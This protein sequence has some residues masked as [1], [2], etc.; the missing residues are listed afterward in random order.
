MY[1][2]VY[3]AFQAFASHDY[4]TAGAEIG[5]AMNDLSQWTTGHS[6]SDDFCYVVTGIMQAMGDMQG[7]LRSCKADFKNFTAAFGVMHGGSIGGGDF[8]FNTDTK[9]LHAGIKDIGYGLEDVSKG[10]GD[11]HLAEL[12]ELL[13]KLA[14]K[15]GV[16]P[17]IGWIEEVLHILIEGVHVEQELGAAMVDYGNNNWVGFGYNPAKLINQDTRLNVLQCLPLCR[18]SIGLLARGRRGTT[19]GPGLNHAA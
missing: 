1:P 13:S 5:K 19:G 4:R 7:D 2:E 16:V 9:S 6:C 14:I 11:C 12:A 18:G 8:H 17:E 10:V 3:G 15:L